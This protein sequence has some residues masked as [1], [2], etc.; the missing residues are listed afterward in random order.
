MQKNN[1]L[2]AVFT[3]IFLVFAG[4]WFANSALAAEIQASK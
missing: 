1:P 4:L 2:Q 3:S